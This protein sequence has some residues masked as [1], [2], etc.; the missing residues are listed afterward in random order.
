MAKQ[1]SNTASRKLRGVKDACREWRMEIDMVERARN[2][3][4]EGDWDGKLRRREAEGVCRDVM[5]GFEDVCKGM[6]RRIA[7]FC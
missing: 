5:G 2:W 3:I 4:E 6:E 1:Q 7:G